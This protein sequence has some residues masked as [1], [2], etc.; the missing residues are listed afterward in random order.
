MGEDGTGFGGPGADSGFPLQI[1]SCQRG[2]ILEKIVECVA[3]PLRPIRTMNPS[4]SLLSVL[5]LSSAVLTAHGE[6]IPR[7]PSAAPT[8]PAA[9][10]SPMSAEEKAKFKEQVALLEKEVAK[11]RGG[12]HSS[13]I[14][15]LKE[16]MSSNEK[17]FNFWL[18]CKK[19]QDF[20]M[21]GKT[22]TEFAEWKRDQIKK[23]GT[24]DAFCAGLRLQLHFLMLSVL[25]SHAETPDQV[26][27]VAGS[28]VAYVETLAA[29]CEKEEN[30]AK[31]VI[32]SIMD[33]GVD[34]NE[35]VTADN[36]QETL[37]KVREASSALGGDVLNSIF[38]KHLKLDGSVKPRNGTTSNPG[39]IDEI[40]DSMI[41]APLRKK[42]DATGV[43]AAW[44]KRIDQTGRVA[45]ATKVKEIEEE[46]QT[47]KVPAMKFAMY[48]DQFASG[49]EKAAA[50]SMMTLIS[51]NPTHKDSNDWMEALKALSDD[52]VKD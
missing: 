12:M 38:A 52:S 26:A 13:Q 21:K 2:W 43:A 50:A 9:P 23:A 42:R 16:A 51:S 8:T 36:I 11:K 49:Q 48:R 27:E 25:D 19:E 14:S 15:I 24:N 33:T 31:G 22:A 45:K 30:L 1:M 41:I 29:F 17:A 35:A 47:V 3:Y 39:N 5:L 18:D 28:A 40:Y 6:L 37:S 46:Y 10:A 32:G 7:K 44:A 4:F 34:P 20:D